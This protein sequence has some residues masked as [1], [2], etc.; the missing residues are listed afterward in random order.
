MVAAADPIAASA[1][2]ATARKLSGLALSFKRTTTPARRRSR[3]DAAKM[4]RNRTTEIGSTAL[5][6]VH[7]PTGHAAG[8]RRRSTCRPSPRTTATT[9]T[10]TA[11]CSTRTAAP[12]TGT[13]KKTG[14]YQSSPPLWSLC[15]LPRASIRV[16][17]ASIR[18][19]RAS[20][21]VPRA[22]IESPAPRSNPPR[23]DRVCAR[24]SCCAPPAASPRARRPRTIQLAPAASPRG[25]LGQ[26]S[27][28][29]SRVVSRTT[30]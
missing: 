30:I 9:T 18:V 12:R 20:I 3:A 24:P 17:R 27:P 11:V 16:P 25:V 29:G 26:T 23:L 15:A 14:P 2:A 6:N 28:S 7:P 22:S 4:S 1:F 19:P 10:I 5:P 8:T 13:C 21:R